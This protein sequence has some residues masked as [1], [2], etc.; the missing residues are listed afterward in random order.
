MHVAK[1][2]GDKA[3]AQSEEAFDRQTAASR[4]QAFF[5]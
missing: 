1:T 4:E 2:A 5:R 3:A